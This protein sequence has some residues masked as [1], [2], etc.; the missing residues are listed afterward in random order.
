MD[1]QDSEDHSVWLAD[2][3]GWCLCIKHLGSMITDA[4]WPQLVQAFKQGVDSDQ[5]A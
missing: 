2:I 5:G 4:C 3:Q 1:I